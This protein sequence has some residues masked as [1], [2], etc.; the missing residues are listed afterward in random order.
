MNKENNFSILNQKSNWDKVTL[1][2]ICEIDPSKREIAHYDK[3]IQVSFGMMADLGEHSR[4]F[5]PTQTKSIN[6]TSKGGYSYFRN[7]DVLLAKMTPC[8]ENG[9]SGIA[10]NLQNDIG[11]GSTEFY[12][13]RN[14][15]NSIP[16]WIYDIISS[17]KFIEEGNHS[18]VGTTGRR[19]LMKQYVETFQIPIPPIEEQKRIAALFQLIEK[20]KEQVECHE[21]NLKRLR[22]SLINKLTKKKPKFGNLIAISNCKEFSIGDLAVEVPDRTD[23][24]KN[25][26]IEKFIGLEDF[27][28]GELTIQRYSST[29]N[30]VSAMKLCKQGDVLFARRNAYLKRASL[31][32]FDAVCSGDV[33]IMRA[34]EKVIFPKFLILILNTDEFWEY[35]ISNAAGTMSKRVKWRDLAS[36]KF[37]LPELNIQAQILEVFAELETAL[38]QIK[39]HKSNLMHLKQR[40]LNEILE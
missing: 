40:L 28:S 15:E 14:K 3:S 17:E 2:D 27:E 6:E 18:L 4:Y 38:S 32:E 12:V 29:E 19:R 24:P 9:K 33:I 10:I 5:S 20:A 31:T 39:L 25:S 13:L 30:L 37:E 36:Y 16:D 1:S 7:G 23:N 21:I 34:N 8:F 26:G 22:K 11:F 35:A